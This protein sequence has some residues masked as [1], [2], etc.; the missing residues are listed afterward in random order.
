MKVRIKGVYAAL[1]T[2]GGRPRVYYYHR[3]TGTRLPD[4][5]TS[6]EFLDMVARLNRPVE[7]DP[8]AAKRAA[9]ALFSEGK[10]SREAAAPP[11]AAPAPHAAVP[12]VPAPVTQPPAKAVKPTLPDGCF[13]LLFKRFKESTEF[14]DLEGNTQKEYARH[15]RHVE[16]VLGFHP[17]SAF[18]A[19]LMDQ[20]IAKFRKH[21]TLQKAIRRTMSVLLGYAMRILKWIPANP[22]LGVQKVRRRGRQE[23]GDRLPLSEPAIARFR[24]ANP[25]GSRARLMFELGLV[26]GFRREDLARVPAEAIEA[27]EIPLRTGKAGILVVAPVTEQLVLALR[28]FRAHHPEHA[29]AV[30]A[31]GAQKNGNPVHKRTISRDFEDAAK[32]AKF[33]AHERLHALRYTAATRLCELGMHFD[34]IAEVTGHAMASM[35]RH[36]CKRRTNAVTRVE[37]LAAFGDKPYRPETLPDPSPENSLMTE[38]GVATDAGAVPAAADMAD[39]A[40]E[41][42][43]HGLR[44]ATRSRGRG[45]CNPAGAAATP[46]DPK[47]PRWCPRRKPRSPAPVPSDDRREGR[48]PTSHAR[49]E[50]G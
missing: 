13:K 35:A 49:E 11:A 42:S 30:Y 25:L 47:A 17:V 7:Q 33:T 15:M 45:T 32:K 44:R 50:P 43:S 23:A 9:S 39:G 2:V 16:P 6:P 18:T 41:G 36:Y 20:L 29:D 48:R 31:L 3:K 5:P 4:D 21:R 12:P 37:M 24:T 1:R 46:K 27:G 22:L 34:D 26:T 40:Q 38:D 14:T 19:D 10:R 28:A 8:E